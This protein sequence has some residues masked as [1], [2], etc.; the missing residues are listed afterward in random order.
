[1]SASEFRAGLLGRKLGHSL[2]PQIHRFFGDYGYSMN[3]R[4]PE[5]AAAFIRGSGLDLLNVTI[6]YKK[7]AAETCDRL[8]PLAER[9]GN[10]NLVLRG[11]GGA[12]VGDNTDYF[13]FS[14]LLDSIGADGRRAAVLG[15]GGAAMTAKAV[16]E[17]RGAEVALVRRGETPADDYDLIVNATPVGMFPDIDGVRIDISRHARCAAVVDLVYN[18]SPTRL[19]REAL[20][21][22]KRAADGMV[23]LIAQAY[24]A[25]T[26]A[27]GAIPGNLYLYG[28][29]ASGKSTWARRIAAATGLG[30]V[31]LD[32]EIERSAGRPIPEIFAEGGEPAFRAIERALL[33]RFAA[34]GGRV[35]A[36]GGGALLDPASRSLAEETGRVVLLSCPDGELLR[37]ARLSSERPLLAGETEKRLAA[38]L[39]A[40]RS[41][42]ASFASKVEFT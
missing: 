32:A 39:A 18:P 40:R 3:E 16:L 28:P 6:P 4:E 13:G 22:G 27:G 7:V 24:R 11:E 31:D 12:L 19:V 36:L 35:V 8:T 20:A 9:L 30:L 34:E 42:Y 23:M 38:L 21:A 1:M 29:P 5:D 25:F 41:H 10:V 26:L 37:R 2:S 17:D 14:R 15:A 33:E